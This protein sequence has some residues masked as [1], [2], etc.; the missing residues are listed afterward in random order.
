MAT[1]LILGLSDLENGPVLQRARQLG[2]DVLISANRLS[3]WQQ[4]D[5]VREWCGF[6]TT[7]LALLDG[8]NC[9]LD[10]AGFVAMKRYNGFPWSAEAYVALA[11]AYPFVR[12]ASMDYCVEEEIAR[13][14]G[15]VR[16]RIARTV[17]ANYLCYSLG[18]QHSISHTFMPVIQ[19]RSADDYVRCIEAMA[20]LVDDH[21][22]VGVGSMC[23]R[24]VHGPDGILQVISILDQVLAGRPTRLHLFGLKS[25]GAEAVRAHPRVF[26][27]DSQ[28]YG[29]AARWDAL[30]AGQVKTNRFVA[31]VM[32]K[33]VDGQ[34]RRLAKGGF[35]FQGAL[36]LSEPPSHLSAWDVAEE[37]ARA[38]LRELIEAG[39]IDHDQ[40]TDRWVMEL[41]GQILAGEE[42]AAP[43][44]CG[45]AA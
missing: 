9:W 5:G 36:A 26:S 32:E 20:S 7:P 29:T 41:A 24:Q 35:A 18:R 40:I 21:E 1:R 25:Q 30:K 19:G 23:R 43:A 22:V 33:W 14:K 3:Q 42:V 31:D 15:E 37:K 4:I 34:R 45:L 38:Q 16:D 2:A 12:W 27:V 39:E 6:R 44:D 28:A 17:G 13:H 10:S 8:L 11:A